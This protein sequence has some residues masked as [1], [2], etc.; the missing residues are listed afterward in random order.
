MMAR[1]FAKRGINSL[2]GQII[3][4]CIVFFLAFLVLMP[5]LLTFMMSLKTQA[6]FNEGFW[7]FPKTPVW[8][9]YGASFFTVLPNMGNSILIAAVVS[10]F[11]VFISSFSS[12]VFVHRKFF[13]KE[14]IFTL[15]LSL[16]IV[17][18]VMT[19]T[20][21]YLTI[22]NM[23]L[24]NTWLGVVLPNI[25]GSLVGSVFLFRTFMGQQPKE[26]FESAN[27][28][29]ANEFVR[30]FYLALPMSLPIIALQ[31]VTTFS[32]IYG[33]YLWPFLIIETE[34]KQ[35]L[36]PMLQKLIGDVMLETKQPGVSY[37]MY[38]M[39]SI[40]LVFTSAFGLK[41]FIN[42]DF[43]AGLKL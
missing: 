19:M 28:D 16:M 9:N 24:K 2:H 35:T 37:A 21:L 22:V 31:L 6:E 14:A 25:S 26:L 20:P 1:K 42:G 43:A 3:L 34:S 33:D 32:T 12:Y 41:Y 10:F 23:N 5:L 15:F 18:S 11:A 27:I 36:M 8:S 13:G 38:L 4:H 39:C 29:G 7:V 17:P 30:Y 40:P